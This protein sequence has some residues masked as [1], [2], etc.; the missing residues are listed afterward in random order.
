MGGRIGLD[1]PQGTVRQGQA[2]VGTRGAVR[3]HPIDIN[4]PMVQFYASVVEDGHPGYW[5]P[6]WARQQ[7][8]AIQSPPGMLMVWGM[9]FDWTPVAA[10]NS[11]GGA[12]NIP[13][14]GTTIINVSTDTEFIRPM[15]VGDR[16]STQEQLVA[17][18]DEKHTR[19]GTGCFLTTRT[20]YHNQRGELVA[21]HTNEVF[22]YTPS[23][24]APETAE[25][26]PAD[27]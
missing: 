1:M 4:W 3:Y 23:Q 16:L 21:I 6:D 24:P 5:D 9:P 14:P 25:E 7:S 27:A 11:D 8:G 20:A 18:S 15:L 17:V 10:T 19:L 13:L 2:L 12:L 26:G 22:R